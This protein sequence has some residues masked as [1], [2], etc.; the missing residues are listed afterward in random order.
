MSDVSIGARRGGR[1]RAFTLIELLVVIAIIAILAAILFPVF[2][3][4]RAKARQA[5]CISNLKQLNL[6]ILMYAQDYDETYPYWSWILSAD[7]GSC[8]NPANPGACGHFESAW[9]TAIYPYVKNAGVYACPQDPANITPFNSQITGWT[10]A[11]DPTTVGVNP[12]LVNAK[13]S[14][15]I[16]EPLHFGELF[17]PGPS[18]SPTTL[19]TLPKPAQTFLITDSYWPTTGS[20]YDGNG[21]WQVLP[22]ENNP[23][24]PAH[25][26]IVH[27]VAFP[28]RPDLIFFYPEPCNQVD[29]SWENGTRHSLGSEIGYADGHVGFLRDGRINNDLYFGTQPNG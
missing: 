28:N 2:A 29:P 21:I 26:C 19:A 9:F 1:R 23:N 18:L 11:T 16:S 27:R 7:A 12:A 5:A 25:Y 8:P 17:G 10:R 4:A 15:G 13:M 14:Y 20:L 22:D 24:D 6:A 3:Q